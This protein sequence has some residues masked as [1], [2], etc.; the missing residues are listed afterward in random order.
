MSVYSTIFT[1]KEWF[2]VFLPEVFLKEAQGNFEIFPIERVVPSP[3]E[4]IKFWEKSLERDYLSNLGEIEGIGKKAKIILGD[5][6]PQ[7]KYM[8]IK[9]Q[10]KDNKLLFI[11]VKKCLYERIKGSIPDIKI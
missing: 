11:K 5:I 4:Q 2:T 1:L 3:S 9:Y 10:I 6:F 7:K 8:I